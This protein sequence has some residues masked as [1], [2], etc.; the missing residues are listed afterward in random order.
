MTN[1]N[2]WATEFLEQT[3]ERM[4]ALVDGFDNLYE[5]L[6]QRVEKMALRINMRHT[7]VSEDKTFGSFQPPP[8][9]VIRINPYGAVCMS[10]ET[11]E[12]VVDNA[13]KVGE[14]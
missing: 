12:E 6:C 10:R 13:L 4:V 14:D 11:F 1:F 5:E 8:K 2:K 7:E 3:Q 9:G